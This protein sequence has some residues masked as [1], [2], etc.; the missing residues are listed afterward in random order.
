[1]TATDPANALQARVVKTYVITFGVVDA[2][3]PGLEHFILHDPIIRA[4]WNH[5]PLVYCV[6]TLAS[7]SE[8]AQRIGPFFPRGT[9]FIAEVN[10]LNIDG[11]LPALA[12]DWFYAPLPPP[13]EGGVLPS[14]LPPLARSG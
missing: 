13:R 8:V 5:I 9:F 11:S 2:N 12:W 10:P 14:A 1:M 3:L 4:Y 7:A 6:K